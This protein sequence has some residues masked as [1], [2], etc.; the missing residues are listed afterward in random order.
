MRPDVDPYLPPPVVLKYA[1]YYDR[2]YDV[3]KATFF[4]VLDIVSNRRDI[5]NGTRKVFINSIPGN[6]LHGE[7]AERLELLARDL[8]NT[9]VVEITEWLE[10]SDEDLHNLKE[11]YKK[12]GFNTAIDD[13]GAGYSNV[14]NLLR[15]MPNGVKIDRMLLSN[16]QDS[17]QKQHF[18]KDIITFSHD[19]NINVI[20]EGVETREE[21]QTVIQLGADLVQGYY[22]ARPGAEIIPTVT[23]QIKNEILEFSR[24]ASLQVKK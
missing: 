17:P 15:Y 19:N 4:N 22:I 18:V 2:M 20:A 23:R 12:V 11:Y 13:Y 10:L 14:T 7:D 3:E 1:G 9:V 16:I 5:F 24:L 8:L 6:L 21:L